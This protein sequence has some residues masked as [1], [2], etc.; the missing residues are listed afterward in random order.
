MHDCVPVPAAIILCIFFVKVCLCVFVLRVNATHTGICV[1]LCEWVSVFTE[2][3]WKER[4]E[5][6]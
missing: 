1:W 5:K 3:E 6:K 2:T 4:H